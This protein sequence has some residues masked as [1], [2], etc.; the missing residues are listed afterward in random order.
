M[1]Q[2]DRY[3]LRRRLENVLPKYVR[4]EASTFTNLHLLGIGDDEISDCERNV[5][6]VYSND[7]FRC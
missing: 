5:S 3:T 7:I 1:D 4:S 2:L 6:L